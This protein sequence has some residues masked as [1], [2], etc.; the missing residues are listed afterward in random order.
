MN[1]FFSSHIE[2]DGTRIGDGAPVYI[3]AEMSAN[4]GQSFEQAVDI[5]HAAKEAGAD[6]V[7]LQT[8]TADTLTLDCQRDEFYIKSGPWQGQYLHDLYKTAYMPWEWHEPLQKI[9]REI[10]I[11]VFSAPFDATAVELLESL[12]FPAHKIASPELI[13]IDLI[14]Q[15]SATGKPVIV[16]TGGGT[17]GEIQEVLNTVKSTGN[18]QLCLMKCTSAYPAPLE[19]MNLR[20]IPHLKALYGG[21]VGLSDHSLGVSVPIAS[22]A[23]GV[24]MIEKHFILSKSDKTADSFFSLDK[25][26]FAH[27]VQGVREAEAALGQVQYPQQSNP[28]RRSLYVVADL[29]AGA[30]ITVENVR[31]LRPGVGMEPKHLQD[32]VGRKLK[33]AAS[34][35]EPLFWDMLE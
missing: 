15:A 8:Y 17:L 6:A 9:A 33:R 21:P 10:G 32:I 4:H 28:A 5:M 27:M 23:L 11:T 20:T 29:Q 24:N 31:N 18:S 12:D 34:R 16:S 19:D 3:V 14:R 2:I 25:S 13:D 7:K 1:D 30:E 26:E 22:V 35:G